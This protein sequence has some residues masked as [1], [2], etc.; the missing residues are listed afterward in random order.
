MEANRFARMA[1]F[2]VNV[3]YNQQSIIL[4]DPNG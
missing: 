1:M 2:V 4:L 3:I